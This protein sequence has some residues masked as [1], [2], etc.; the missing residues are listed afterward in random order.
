M[1]L[2]VRMMVLLTPLPDAA[3][4]EVEGTVAVIDANEAADARNR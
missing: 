4:G 3:E 1:A 2:T